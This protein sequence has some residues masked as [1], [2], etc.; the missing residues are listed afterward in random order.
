MDGKLDEE[1]ICNDKISKPKEGAED[2]HKNGK[3]ALDVG[4]QAG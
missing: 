3:L 1:S 2:I 4:A